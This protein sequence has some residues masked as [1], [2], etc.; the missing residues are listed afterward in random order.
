LHTLRKYFETQCT[1]AGVK[2]TYGEFWMGHIGRHLAESYFRGE[3]ETHKEYKKAVPYL[4]VLA[5]EPQDYK[6]L[7]EK[8][9]F[10]EE[11][12]R[13]KDMEI[14]KLHAQTAEN[15]ELKRRTQMTEKKL[16]EI[17]GTVAEL[18]KLIAELQADS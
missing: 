9:R 14:Q 17:E 8:V 5:A 11:N 7:V 16:A 3:V 2:T 1:N 15:V 10:L 13:R 6:A 4:S 18:K 12:G